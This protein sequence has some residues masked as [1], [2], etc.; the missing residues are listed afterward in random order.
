MFKYCGLSALTSQIL[1]MGGL[2]PLKFLNKR[3]K[4]YVINGKRE[5]DH[6]K[7]YAPPENRVVLK[8]IDLVKYGNKSSKM[9]KLID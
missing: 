1:K 5:K 9:R 2:G 3:A 4:L 6:T 8:H 7:E